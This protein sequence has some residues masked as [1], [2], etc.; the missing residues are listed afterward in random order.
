MSSPYF[1]IHSVEMK[2]GFAF[3]DGRLG[4]VALKIGHVFDRSFP[5]TE[6]WQLKEEGLPCALVVR[7][8]EA[9]R[10]PL[11]ELS[12]GMTARLSIDGSHLSALKS[13]AVIE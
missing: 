3:V 2:D 8:I 7:G 10:K 13:A 12:P 6:A 9:Y 1:L 5:R 11:D 4:E